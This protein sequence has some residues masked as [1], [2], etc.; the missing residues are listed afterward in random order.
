M[1]RKHLGGQPK[2]LGLIEF[3]INGQTAELHWPKGAAAGHLCAGPLQMANLFPAQDFDSAMVE[4]RTLIADL[5]ISLI[6]PNN[7]GV[8]IYGERFHFSKERNDVSR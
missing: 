3:F 8:L 1:G 6:Q 7:F 4:V 2:K 5:S